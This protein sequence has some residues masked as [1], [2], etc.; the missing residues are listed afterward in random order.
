MKSRV[1]VIKAHRVRGKRIKVRVCLRLLV[2]GVLAV[3][4][5]HAQNH[6]ISELER[7][8]AVLTTEIE[9]LKL[10][11]AA[12]PTYKPAYGFAPAAAK[13]YHVKKGVSLGGYGELVYENFRKR[14]EDGTASGKKNQLDFLRLVLYTGYKF[15]DRIL[16]NSEIEFEHAADDKKGEVAVEFAYLDFLWAKPLG[17]RAGLLLMPVGFLN[18]MHEPPVF[19]G[20]N[21]PNVERNL[22]PTT[23][24]ENGVGLFGDIGPLTYR[25]YVVAGLRAIKSAGDKIDGFTASSGVRG[26]RQ[27]GS[28]SL[29][30]DLAWTGRV[31]F[32]GIPGLLVGA[33]AYTGKSGQGETNTA[34][35]E[36][37]A[38]TTLWDVHGQ[39]EWRG[40]E[41]R[42]LYGRGRVNDAADINV[43]NGLTGNA[44]VG[45]K[46]FG[47]YLQ[48]AYDVL[49][50]TGSKHYL[51][52]FFRYE[53]YNTQ[54]TVPAG[55]SSNP[56]N[57]RTEYAYGV[58]Y[59]PI[60]QAVFKLDYQDM[61]NRGNTGVD[62]FNLGVGYL[63]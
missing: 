53:R 23:W 58:T 9:R 3:P 13:V 12:E 19:H 14:R 20:A 44:S 21:R 27:K 33:A 32:V 28:K 42:G 46:M 4:P 38:R 11:E 18:E 36:I 10:G 43:K 63:F 49:S 30:E 16:F 29:A 56:S 5:L 50:L 31:D 35:Q 41:L 37:G 61:N 17:L 51:A 45:E 8:L 26:G 40:L 1:S 15:T 60:P 54:H 25:T 7:K 22:I 39:W 55:F 47:G 2:M 24:R 34:G 48:A 6:Q 57:D 59:K 52:P 62:Q